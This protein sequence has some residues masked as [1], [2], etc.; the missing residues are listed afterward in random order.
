[1]SEYR[2]FDAVAWDYPV[3][4]VDVEALF[5]RSETITGKGGFYMDRRGQHDYRPN[6]IFNQQT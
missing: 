6:F 1:M 2:F 3:I 4:A 5:G